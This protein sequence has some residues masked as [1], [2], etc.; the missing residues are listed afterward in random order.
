MSRARVRVRG[1]AAGAVTVWSLVEPPD[2][3]RWYLVTGGFVASTLLLL[4]SARASQLDRT[5]VGT[6]AIILVYGAVVSH[7]GALFGRRVFRIVA[8]M[9]LLV[10]L[11]LALWGG[12]WVLPMA[13]FIVRAL[14]TAKP[15]RDLRTGV[16]VGSGTALAGMIIAAAVLVVPPDQP[17]LWA[18]YPSGLSRPDTNA[19]FDALSTTTSRGRERLPQ[20]AGISVRAEGVQVGVDSYASADDVKDLRRRMA[21]APGV[22]EVRR[23]TPCPN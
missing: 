16:I 2:H 15:R 13:A 21:A 7:L 14:F 1:T 6:V 19:L 8:G 4:V 22:S 9:D 3:L 10:L 12:W 18:C 5:G 17:S 11:Y 20:V 23:G